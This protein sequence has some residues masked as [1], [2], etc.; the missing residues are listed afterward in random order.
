[1]ARQ[2]KQPFT[3]E[4]AMDTARGF[5]RTA[6]LVEEIHMQQMAVGHGAED[7]IGRAASAIVLE[8]LA[9][10]LVLKARLV[11]EVARRENA[12]SRQTVRYPPGIGAAGNRAAISSDPTSDDASY[13]K[14]S[15]SIQRANL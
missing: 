8:A 3:A 1:M 7:F 2:T 12:R 11:A 10:E 5:Y 13:V 9:L 14:G 6:A 15:I 4:A